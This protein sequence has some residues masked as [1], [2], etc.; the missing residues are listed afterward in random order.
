MSAQGP[1]PRFWVFGIGAK[2]L[3]PGLENSYD[4]E[5]EIKFGLEL[6][7]NISRLLTLVFS[8][9]NNEYS[10]FLIFF[11]LSSASLSMIVN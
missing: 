5:L 2:G 11:F 9:A 7:N 10:R 1:A 3:G 6:L 4:L 8:P